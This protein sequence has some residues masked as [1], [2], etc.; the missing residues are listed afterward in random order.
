VASAFFPS[1]E[2]LS[3]RHSIRRLSEIDPPE[4]FKIVLTKETAESPVGVKI[5]PGNNGFKIT[6]TEEEELEIV[7]KV[8]A[9]ENKVCSLAAIREFFH[10]R[11]PAHY[12]EYQKIG[13]N[14]CPIKRHNV[15]YWY[16]NFL[17]TGKHRKQKK[18]TKIRSSRKLRKSNLKQELT[19]FKSEPSEGDEMAIDLIC[20]QCD[21]ITDTEEK[22]KNHVEEIHTARIY[23]NASVHAAVRN[24]SALQNSFPN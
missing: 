9:T 17:R 24:F 4:P 6:L 18:S 7:K 11:F 8:V 22:L 3:T 1:P 14:K 15:H 20:D 21:F 5:A 23:K 16:H 12:D 13:W 19:E 2:M 10:E